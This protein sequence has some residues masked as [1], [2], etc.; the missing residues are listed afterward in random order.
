MNRLYPLLFIV[1][2]GC[3]SH[4]SAQRTDRQRHGSV[5]D[6]HY[7]LSHSKYRFIASLKPDEVTISSF[8][9]SELIE[10]RLISKAMFERLMHITLERFDQLKD[11]APINSCRTPF[12]ILIRRGEHE[13]ATEGCR[14]QD[15]DGHLGE[16][17]REG[18]H[19]FY[20]PIKKGE[21]LKPSP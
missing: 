14:T 2:I 6:I 21:G 16:I 15:Q 10:S 11:L 1:L 4:P 9:D 20:L 18:E 19:L 12:T 7:Q 13:Q 17:L 8:K 3:A 5:I